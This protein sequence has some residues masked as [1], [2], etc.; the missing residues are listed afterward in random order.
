MWNSVNNLK[1]I[2]IILCVHILVY[3]W[4]QGRMCQSFQGH[5]REV[6][7]VTPILC[8]RKLIKVWRCSELLHVTHC[9]HPLTS[10]SIYMPGV[11]LSRQYVDLQRL[12]GQDCVDVGPQPGGRTYP[13]ILWAWVGG[14]RTSCQPWYTHTHTHTH[15]HT[16]SLLTC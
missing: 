3:D 14:Q 5:N 12:T 15:T 13:G 7:K 16:I 2:V 9:I 4:K 6:T 11:V 10:A 8:V 1:Q